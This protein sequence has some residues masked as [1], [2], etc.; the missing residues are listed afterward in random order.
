MRHLGIDYGTRRIGIAVSDEGGRLATPLAVL[1]VTSPE[2]GLRRVG[3][4]VAEHN[5]RVLVVG[6]PLNMDDSEGPAAASV[7]KWAAQLSEGTGRPVVFVDERLSSFEAG[8]TLK[9]RKQAGERMTRRGRK[10]R[11]DALAAAQ[12][13]QSYLDSRTEGGQNTISGSQGGNFVA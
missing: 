8:Q 4:L 3:E 13:L 5:A 10:Q 12:L 1:E 2:I 11:L 9:A 7:R 6:L